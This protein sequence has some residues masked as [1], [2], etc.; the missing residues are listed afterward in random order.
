MPDY[1]G[2]PNKLTW[3]WGFRVYEQPPTVLAALD[4]SNALGVGGP[5]A[6]RL[7]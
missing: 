7:P 6:L 5:S 2:E 1:T 4:Y 3:S